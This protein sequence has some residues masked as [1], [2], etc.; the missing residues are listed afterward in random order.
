VNLNPRLWSTGQLSNAVVV[1]TEHRS[2]EQRLNAASGTTTYRQAV[3]A[4]LLAGAEMDAQADKTE[5]T[6]SDAVDILLN[7]VEEDGYSALDGVGEEAI[8]NL[9]VI[10][11]KFRTKR[12]F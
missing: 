2:S 8:I 11:D 3:A 12:G 1:L 7:A 10:L 4:G 9:C 5:P 6:V